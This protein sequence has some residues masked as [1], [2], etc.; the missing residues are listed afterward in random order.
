MPFQSLFNTWLLILWFCDSVWYVNTVYNIW[1]CHDWINYYYYY[2]YNSLK[3]KQWPV[4]CQIVSPDFICA[5]KPLIS[6]LT[7][8]SLSAACLRV[9]SIRFQSDHSH[10]KCLL[11]QQTSCH[12]CSDL[13]TPCRLCLRKEILWWAHISKPP[14]SRW[15]LQAEGS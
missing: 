9:I 14:N 15:S 12:L 6:F 1:C 2:Y 8:S 7:L 4:A 10:L 5:V 3:G 13:I 11:Q